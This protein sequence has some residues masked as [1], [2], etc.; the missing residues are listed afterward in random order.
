MSMPLAISHEMRNWLGCGE[1]SAEARA[2]APSAPD[3]ASGVLIKGVRRIFGAA[4][5]ARYHRRCGDKRTPA[6]RLRGRQR[7]PR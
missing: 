1:G 6:A 4:R 7:V 5:P 3:L 2:H